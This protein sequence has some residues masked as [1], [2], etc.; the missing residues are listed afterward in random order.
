VIIDVCRP[1]PI[2]IRSG[3][4]YRRQQLTAVATING[5]YPINYIVSGI[6][7][8]GVSY[9]YPIQSLPISVRAKGR[10]VFSDWPI[11]GLAIGVTSSIKATLI[12]RD[13]PLSDYTITW[14]PSPLSL[15]MF[16]FAPLSLI[17]NATTT[18][19][20]LT[21]TITPFFNTSI[22]INS[23]TWI[24]A[25]AASS[26]GSE[27][28]AS[29]SD[30]VMV[31]E[32]ETYSINIPSVMTPSYYYTISILLSA[33]PSISNLTFEL[34]SASDISFIPSNVITFTPTGSLIQNVTVT[35]GDSFT[36]GLLTYMVTGANASQYTGL[37]SSII[38]MAPLSHMTVT[39]ASERL[40]LMAKESGSVCVNL[41]ID[42]LP[43][44]FVSFIVWVDT[45][46]GASTLY[47]PMGIICAVS[48][49]K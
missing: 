25:P 29:V 20:D 23:I 32:L 44:T 38:S 15:S 49:L 28:A 45:P 21:F 22:G 7:D 34:V 17:W 36:G 14:T 18:N 37:S 13:L 41:S 10:I 35:V 6:D 9:T 8:N 46:R 40:S 30:D 3:T 1:N 27:W 48:P 31:V 26:Y 12:N 39:A 5:I 2:V 47:A 33:L 11:D 24:S 16:T 42:A 43:Q 4:I 19:K